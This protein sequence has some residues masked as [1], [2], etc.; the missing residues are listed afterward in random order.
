MNGDN[1]SGNGPVIPP[2]QSLLKL[3]QCLLNFGPDPIQNINLLVACCGE[4]LRGA[5]ALYSRLSEGMLHTVGQWRLP[6]GLA[7]IDKA[8]GHISFDVL[9][10]C[11][12]KVCLFRNLS[13]TGYGETDPNVVKFGLQTYF[14]KAVSFGGVN[15]GT[16]CVL[17]LQDRVPSPEE[18]DLLEIAACAIGVEER[19]KGAE[20]EILRLNAELEKKVEERTAQLEAANR[21]LELFSFS[22]SHDLHTSLMIVEGF[23]RELAIKYSH[24]L[25]D[26]GRHYLERLQAAS[27]RMKQIA[28]AF[29]KISQITRR[30]LNREWVNLSEMVAVIS[31]DL[32]QS[33]PVRQV[34]FHVKKDVIVYG[35]KRL[36]KVMMENLLAN[37]WKYTMKKEPA[38]IEFG[39]VEVEG[40]TACFVSDNGVG[41]DMALADRLFVA[42]Q[43][44]HSEEEFAGYGI[45]LA[46]VQRIIERHGGSIWAHGE[47]GKGAT[48]YF[49]LPEGEP[50]NGNGQ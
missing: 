16:L 6:Q 32:R 43:R 18:A 15:F 45:G 7:S 29:L 9:R 35:D 30:E 21:E 24:R 37:A 36:L 41:F 14:G 19:R 2:G 40:E 33:Y 22:V 27:R 49:R 23:S 42:F 38:V 13:L 3:K 11:P 17:F 44:L 50:R 48:F 46:T 28:E 5:W 25:D 10:R 26:A 31:G 47:V 20:D 12:D 34:K 8:E 39:T 4:E 1:I